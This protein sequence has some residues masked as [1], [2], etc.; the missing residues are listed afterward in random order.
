MRDR[1]QKT[2]TGSLQLLKMDCKGCDTLAPPPINL[3]DIDNEGRGSEGFWMNARG[4]VVKWDGRH[5]RIDDYPRW[6]I[7]TLWLAGILFC[8]FAW[9]IIIKIFQWIIK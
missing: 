5:L 4:I 8:I 3:G 7:P 1:S 6:I 2:F 9:H